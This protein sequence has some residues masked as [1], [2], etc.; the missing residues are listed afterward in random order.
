MKMAPN[1]MSKW[2]TLSVFGSDSGDEIGG[3]VSGIVG[4]DS[5][6]FEKRVGE[7]LDGQSFFA[8]RGDGKLH[9]FTG[10]QNLGDEMEG[11]G[12]SWRLKC[13]IDTNNW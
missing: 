8:F 6:D 3:V 9:H 10:H 7:S 4:D 1:N 2:R 5:R 13:R 12:L 11:N